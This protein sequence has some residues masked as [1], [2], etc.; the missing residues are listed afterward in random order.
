MRFLAFLL[1]TLLLCSTAT[2]QDAPPPSAL[3][4]QSARVVSEVFTDPALISLVADDIIATRQDEFRRPLLTGPFYESLRPD[5]QRS[6]TAYVDTIP[7][8]FHEE[9]AALVAALREDLPQRLANRFTE[10]ELVTLADLFSRP[11][12]R[13]AIINI[14]RAELRG[15]SVEAPVIDPELEALITSVPHHWDVARV[16]GESNAAVQ[17]TMRPRIEQRILRGVCNALGDECP[18]HVRRRIVPETHAL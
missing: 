1:A 3:E 12:F 14:A 18:P 17:R 4:L 7:Q 5:T 11:E 10:P 15:E 16:V 8:V 2:A 6:L 9:V 13:E